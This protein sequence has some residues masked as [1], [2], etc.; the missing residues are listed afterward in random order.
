MKLILIP[1]Y[2][3]RTK[4]NTD[5]IVPKVKERGDIFGVVSSTF[6]FIF[7]LRNYRITKLNSGQ[8]WEKKKKYFFS[9]GEGRVSTSYSHNSF[10]S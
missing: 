5:L 8:D 4:G 7:K 6:L 3:S 1:L 2:L 9:L 10:G